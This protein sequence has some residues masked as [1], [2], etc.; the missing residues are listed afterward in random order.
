[1][2]NPEFWSKP[3]ALCRL[4]IHAVMPFMLIAPQILTAQG[5]KFTSRDLTWRIFGNGFFGGSAVKRKNEISIDANWEKASWGLGVSYILKSFDSNRELDSIRLQIKNIFGSNTKVYAGL[6]TKIEGNKVQNPKKAVDITNQWRTFEFS[7]ASMRYPDTLAPLIEPDAPVNAK[8][9]NIYF[10]KPQTVEL[11][12]DTIV[13][14]DLVLTFK[15]GESYASQPV[16]Y[17]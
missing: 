11:T 16:D 1:M 17:R 10:T 15:D 7:T 4:L 3:I 13:I 2:I 8:K 6:S 12:A 9:V 14:R 5:S